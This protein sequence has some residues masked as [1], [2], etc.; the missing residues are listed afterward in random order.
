[1]KGETLKLKKEN[2]VLKEKLSNQLN[3]ADNNS[4]SEEYEKG[5]K[6]TADRK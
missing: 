6:K 1:M 2:Q 3:F 4:L 5:I